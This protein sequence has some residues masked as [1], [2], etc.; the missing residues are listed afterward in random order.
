LGSTAF[1]VSVS[2]RLAFA[3]L[4]AAASVA[5]VI[6]AVVLGS[7]AGAQT[8][9]TGGAQSEV[10]HAQYTCGAS[11]GAAMKAGLGTNGFP[12]PAWTAI[13]EASVTLPVVAG[14]TDCIVVSFSSRGYVQ[15]GADAIAYCY[16]RAVSGG[17]TMFPRGFFR[18]HAKS[19]GVSNWEAATQQWIYRITPTTNSITVYMQWQA[20]ASNEFC[21]LE[22]WT[23]I[24]ER[25]Q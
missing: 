15:E 18:Q 4:A 5:A 10:V 23:L 20:G 1:S 6:G 16:V 11:L 8:P 13:P 3:G 24:A 14:N 7:P 25:F 19:Q 17:A 9:P 22:G 2:K 21:N 12:G